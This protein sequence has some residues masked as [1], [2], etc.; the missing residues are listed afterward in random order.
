MQV[1]RLKPEI[2]CFCSKLKISLKIY[3]T[4]GFVICKLCQAKIKTQNKLKLPGKTKAS[5]I[6]LNEVLHNPIHTQNKS[7]QILN[8]NI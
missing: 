3:R 5:D 7:D 1:K 8:L 2:I 6:Y 4:G